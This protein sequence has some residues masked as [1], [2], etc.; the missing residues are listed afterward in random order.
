MKAIVTKYHPVTYAR[1]SRYSA[2]D[3]DG[4]R[5]YSENRLEW[6]S[7]Q[8]HDAAARKLCKKLGW[9][10]KLVRGELTTVKAALKPD[11]FSKVMQDMFPCQQSIDLE[12]G[13]YY[14]RLGVRDNRT[15]LIGTTNAKVAVASAAPAR[16]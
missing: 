6:N 15:G 13:K 11:T 7:E 5:A 10:G 14:L 1:G 9:K 16:P 3:S 12:P 2:T 8:N 4:N